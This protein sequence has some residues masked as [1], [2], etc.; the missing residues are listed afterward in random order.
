MWLEVPDSANLSKVLKEHSNVPSVIQQRRVRRDW[1][2]HVS[3]TLGE[4]VTYIVM[5]Q[6]G[7]LNTNWE[8]MVAVG[9][10][11]F[12]GAE[13]AHVYDADFCAFSNSVENNQKDWLSWQK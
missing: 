8:D 2:F 4:I 7:N 5:I 13:S 12:V 11:F 1:E 3:E 10:Y 6:K 9:F